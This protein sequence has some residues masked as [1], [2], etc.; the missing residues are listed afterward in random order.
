MQ[1]HGG[2]YAT[3]NLKRARRKIFNGNR[4]IPVSYIQVKS[5]GDKT[6]VVNIVVSRE[7]HLDFCDSGPP[8]Y[9]VHKYQISD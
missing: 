7:K 9:Y 2:M 6:L 5:R 3:T 1:T 8:M 4:T